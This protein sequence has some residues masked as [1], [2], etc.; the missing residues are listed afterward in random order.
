MQ[1]AD[2][3]QYRWVTPITSATIP[4]VVLNPNATTPMCVG[5]TSNVHVFAN[6]TPGGLPPIS[7]TVWGYG[8]SPAGIQY[9]GPTLVAQSH[10]GNFV[11]W[12][13]LL[14][15]GISHPCVQPPTDARLGGMVGRYR[16]GYACV[17]LHGGHLCWDSDGHPVR[18]A[19]NGAL[20]R[21]QTT[22]QTHSV[23]FDYANTQ[24]GGALLW[25]HDHVM[26]ATS[27]NVYAGL[28]GGYILR[29]PGEAGIPELPK[30]EYEMPLIIQDRS[31]LA[32][33]DAKGRRLLY[34]HAP[35]LRDR[36]SLAANAGNP[37]I[38]RENIRKLGAPMGEFKGDAMCVNGKVWPYLKVKPRAYRFR[39]LNGCNTRMLVLRLSHEDGK[40]PGEPDLGADNRGLEMLQIGGD[41]GFISPPVPLRGVLVNGQPTT[42]DFLVLASGERADIVIDFSGLAAEQKIYL[43]NHATETSPL[44]NAGDLACGIGPAGE[45][46][47][48]YSVMQFQVLDGTPQPL[49][50]HALTTKLDAIT[51][52]P[53]GVVPA[54]PTRR[55]VINERAVALTAADAAFTLAKAAEVVSKAA[56]PDAAT[57]GYKDALDTITPPGRFGW[58]AITLQPSVS[59]P[60]EPGLLWAGPAPALIGSPP[61]GGPYIDADNQPTSPVRHTIN[62]PVELWEFYNLSADV[63]PMHLHL[64]S[65]Q[66]LS[67]Q[68]ILASPLGPLGQL[69]AVVPIDLNEMGWKD[70]VRVN[71][72][73]PANPNA[74]GQVTRLLVRFHD[75]GDT[76]RNYR[77][78]FVF[79]CHLL[80]HE[81]MGMMRPLEVY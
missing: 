71:A 22:A 21:P 4:T 77:G 56:D 52:M 36:V 54:Q 63:H 53:H 20:L 26:D 30:D 11:E 24:R 29:H 50:Q 32:E 69:G 6:G 17:H 61:A 28:A 10:V 35:Y 2:L 76:T 49:N 70:T 42:S 38:L 27:M 80:E 62:G 5:Q 68:E 60:V 8:S 15:Q 9:P 79:H 12:T 19:G 34:G 16:T 45:E 59:V 18:R 67:R 39:V 14:P 41:A 81:D 75:E 31:F 44:G 72:K 1:L 7:Q 58:K 25:Y 13:N 55:Y 23:D 46:Q 74:I 40:L 78:H 73:D 64:A 65:F 47:L 48:Q 57:K 33:P 3:K 51:H 66:V 43:T 37:K